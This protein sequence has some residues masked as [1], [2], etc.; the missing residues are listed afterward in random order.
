MTKNNNYNKLVIAS[1]SWQWTYLLGQVPRRVRPL[2]C[3]MGVHLDDE[4]NQANE[5]EQRENKAN[6][7][8]LS[9]TF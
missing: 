2:R 9:T 7:G 3:A 6:L 8:G 1:L 5:F 4:Q